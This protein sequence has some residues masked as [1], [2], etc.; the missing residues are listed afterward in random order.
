MCSSLFPYWPSIGSTT[1]TLLSVLLSLASYTCARS[2]P[3]ICVAKM[4]RL[5]RYKAILQI[6]REKC[7]ARILGD[8][9]R[10]GADGTTR[11][12]IISPSGGTTHMPNIGNILDIIAKRGTRYV[13]PRGKARATNNGRSFQEFFFFFKRKL[14][15]FSDFL[16]YFLSVKRAK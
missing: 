14:K 9:R 6:L 3:Q 12:T 7:F 13:N 11:K 2:F 10:T 16:V 8:F 4:R 1:V 5:S 15:F